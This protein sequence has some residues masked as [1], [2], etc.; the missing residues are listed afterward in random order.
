MNLFLIL[1]ILLIFFAFMFVRYNR[2]HP[3]TNVVSL[4]A[5]AL[6]LIL[7]LPEYKTVTYDPVMQVWLSSYPPM[8]TILVLPMATIGIGSFIVPIVSKLISSRI[9]RCGASC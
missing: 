9:Q 7:V 2:N 1:A 8:M 4:F 6:I 5:G 3:A